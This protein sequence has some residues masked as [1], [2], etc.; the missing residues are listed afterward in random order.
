MGGTLLY[1]AQEMLVMAGLVLCVGAIERHAG[2]DDLRRMGG[3]YRRAPVVSVITLVLVLALAGM[4]PLAGF[5][6]KALILREGIAA[7]RWVLVFLT[8]STAVLTLMAALRV[9][10][11]G[12]WMSPRGKSLVAPEGATIGSSPRVG[13][14]VCGAALVLTASIGIGL[15]APR[16]VPMALRG[17][18]NLAE[19][20]RLIDATLGAPGPGVRAV[21]EASNGAEVVR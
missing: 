9:W 8:I 7:G 16:T 6:G 13:W 15:G 5:F 3:L 17:A 20:Q 19:P 2:T 1:M 11:F 14:I 10:C 12:F 21:V 18:L 4:P